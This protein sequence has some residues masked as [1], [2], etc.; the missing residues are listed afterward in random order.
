MLAANRQPFVLYERIKGA[1]RLVALDEKA[2]AFGLSPGQSLADARAMVPGMM[3]LQ[4]DQAAT[5]AGFADFADWHSYASPIVAVLKDMA[6]YGDLVIDIGGAS[7]LFGGEANM[8]AM[9][10]S[11]LRGLGFTAQGAVAGSVGAAFALARFRPGEV[12]EGDGAKMLAPLPVRALRLQEAQVASLVQMGWKT[13]GQLYGRD[14]RSLQA[15]LGSSLVLRLDQALGEMGE[16]LKPRLPAVEHFAEQRFAEPI[17]L[18][19]DVLASVDLLAAQLCSQLETQGLGAQGFHLMLYRV[20]HKVMALS[21]NAVRAMRDPAH[22]GRLFAHRTER[23]KEDFDAGFGI[24]MIRLAADT[25]S[26][27]AAGQKGVF[28]ASDGAEDLD[29]LYDRMTSR[30]GPLS[31]QRSKLANT[32][33]PERAVVLEPALSARSGGDVVSVTG[34]DG[35]RPLRLLPRPEAVNVLAQV[36]YGPPA[37]MVWRKVNYRFV[38]ASGPERIGVEWWHLRQ[39]LEPTRLKEGDP[40]PQ[41]PEG[42]TFYG[43]GEQT[44]DYY[45]AEDEAGRRFWLFRLGLYGYAPNPRWFVHGLFQ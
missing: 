1:F 14:R 42:E 32:H 38:R 21:V 45:L 5:E 25:L 33:I 23:L 31:V 18:I 17:G 20:D 26:P 13:I 9:V 28:S 2:E 37:T 11:K 22:V 24:D 8:L 19:E 6:P 44:R 27:L 16:T 10:T 36:P 41:P 29:R 15:R 39:H 40:V 4:I 35:V 3:G 7:H 12:V 30:L 43:E 34:P